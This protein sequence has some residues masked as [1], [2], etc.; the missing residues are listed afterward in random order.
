MK[1]LFIVRPLL[2][3]LLC[4]CISCGKANPTGYDPS[5]PTKGCSANAAEI[6]VGDGFMRILCG[7][8]GSGEENGK[9]F[10]Y[11]GNLTCHLGANQS[12]VF[13]NF[14][15]IRSNHQIIADGSTPFHSTPVV[16]PSVLRPGFVYGVTFASGFSTFP[17]KDAFSGMK[18]EIVFP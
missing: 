18:G 9:I 10:P 16:T 8:Q 12:V 2:L 1:R 13:F 11:P 7:C 15:G 5:E 4:L 17:F 14:I 3:I 6:Q